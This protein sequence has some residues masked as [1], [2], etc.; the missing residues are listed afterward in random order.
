MSFA[1]WIAIVSVLATIGACV[2]GLL[3]LSVAL[4]LVRAVRQAGRVSTAV[5]RTFERRRKATWREWWFA[6]VKEFGASYT[7][8]RIGSFEIPHNPSLPIRSA[9]A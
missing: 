1:L 9:W 6:F 4:E 5:T 3:L 8:I 2:I 7:T